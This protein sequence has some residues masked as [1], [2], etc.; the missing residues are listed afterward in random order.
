MLNFHKDSAVSFN[1]LTAKPASGLIET[2]N[3]LPVSFKCGIRFL[4]HIETA[5][6]VSNDYLEYLGEF[7]VLF[8]L[9]KKKTKVKNLSTLP[10]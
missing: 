7:A 1:Y 3:P 2:Q 4:C 6:A 9:M 5:E 10:H 8:D